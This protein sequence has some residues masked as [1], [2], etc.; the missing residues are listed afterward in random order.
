MFLE[1]AATAVGNAKLIVLG[2]ICLQIF[3]PK[4]INVL[5]SALKSIGFMA[6]QLGMGMQYPSISLGFFG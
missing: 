2:L 5:M 4:G 6:I 1:D 3:F